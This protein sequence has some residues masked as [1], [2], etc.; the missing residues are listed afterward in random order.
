MAGLSDLYQR[1]ESMRRNPG[2]TA[3][4][5]PVIPS[6]A[7]ID[8]LARPVHLGR[9]RSEYGTRAQPTLP[10]AFSGERPARMG[11]GGPR[12]VHDAPKN[13]YEDSLS[14]FRNEITVKKQKYSVNLSDFEVKHHLGEGSCGQVQEMVHKETQTVMAVKKMRRTQDNLEHKRIITDLKIVMKDHGCPHIVKSYGA[15][16]TDT[17]VCIC[18]EP[19]DTC[20][21]KLLKKMK[22][23]NK[24]GFP[25]DVI[26]KITVAAVDGLHYLK[27]NYQVIHRDV[28]PS[29]ILL[30]KQ[31]HIKICDFGIAGHL[32]DSK[33]KTRNEGCPAY[34]APERIEPP[35]PSNPTYDIR[36]DVWSLGITLYQLALGEHPYSE[37]TTQFQLMTIILKD[38]APELPLDQGFSEDFIDFVGKCLIKDVKFR[39][40]YEELLEHPFILKY[41]DVADNVVGDWYVSNFS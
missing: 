13:N 10:L 37:T 38:P 18:M 21:D 31:G 39:P 40:K 15:F 8:S 25:E 16:V 32:V 6:A 22:N 30:D 27:K 23:T 36:A 12:V 28:K 20:L 17:D 9:P 29:N 1:L 41:Q 4:G 33:A 3:P 11:L 14:N 2:S 5:S 19:M 24:K 35:D 34:M 26:G 7:S